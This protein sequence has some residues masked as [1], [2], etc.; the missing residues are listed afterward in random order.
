MYYENDTIHMTQ[1]DKATLNFEALNDSDYSFIRDAKISIT[2]IWK[3]LCGFIVIGNLFIL[4]MGETIREIL[5]PFPWMMIVICGIAWIILSI[6]YLVS[7][8]SNDRNTNLRK[9]IFEV[10]EVQPTVCGRWN[11]SSGGYHDYFYPV[12]IKQEDYE[13]T[14][15]LSSNAYS[16]CKHNKNVI[17]YWENHWDGNHKPLAYARAVEE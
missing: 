15:F 16:L 17:T 13:T 12:V 1:D 11:N 9:L 6:Y 10:I 14:L 8:K 2:K 7:A 3:K 5:G 4:M